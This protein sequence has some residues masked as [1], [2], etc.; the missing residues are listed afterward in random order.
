[1][2]TESR[3]R[4]RAYLLWEQA[5]RPEGRSEEFWFAA[6]TILAAEAAVPPESPEPADLP[7]RRRRADARVAARTPA[8][9][10]KGAMAKALKSIAT[11][12]AP[13]LPA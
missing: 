5:G 8:R 9:S 7:K 11:P 12:A 3:T 1:M 13:V 2:D 6:A 4:E 10:G